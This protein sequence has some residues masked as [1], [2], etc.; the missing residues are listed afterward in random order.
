MVPIAKV[1]RLRVEVDNAHALDRVLHRAREAF[2]AEAG[3]LHWDVY[4]SDG[5][6]ERTVVE[7]FADPD[8][9]RQHDDSP[10]VAT[11]LAD[12]EALGVDVVAVDQFSQTSAQAKE[13]LINKEH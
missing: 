12:L 13:P 2:H 1:V 11:L 4:D 7:L 6:G 8:A 9:V 5:P 3:T 10:A